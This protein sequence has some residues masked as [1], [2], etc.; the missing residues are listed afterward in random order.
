M[1]TSA[2]E[3]YLEDLHRKA[4]A[5]FPDLTDRHCPNCGERLVRGSI[6]YNYGYH[7]DS[8]D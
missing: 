6:S 3:D 2:Y 4:D 8:C 7:M 1:S 5:E